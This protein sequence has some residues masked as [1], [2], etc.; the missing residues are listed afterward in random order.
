MDID[1]DRALVRDALKQVDKPRRSRCTWRYTDGG[2]MPRIT[3]GVSLDEAA[4]LAQDLHLTRWR[5][6]VRL[7][8]FI[9]CQARQ[10]LLDGLNSA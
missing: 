10:R 8:E 7:P 5:L 4:R 2:S 1:F 6:Y 9:E 3:T